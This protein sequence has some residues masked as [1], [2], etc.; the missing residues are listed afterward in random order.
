MGGK[1]GTLLVVPSMERKDETDWT[2]ARV[3]ES[4]PNIEVFNKVVQGLKLNGW[5]RHG[6]VVKAFS[7]DK[8]ILVLR[9]PQSPVPAGWS[10]TEIAE[11]LR[12]ENQGILLSGR[13]PERWGKPRET[14]LKFTVENTVEAKRLALKGIRWNSH[15]RKVE[16]ITGEIEK[17]LAGKRGY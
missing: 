3:S 4:I 11:Q 10:K 1:S 5:K 16:I 9:A 13:L 6:L 12:K 2:V 15:F 17:L 7:E 14:G 8:R